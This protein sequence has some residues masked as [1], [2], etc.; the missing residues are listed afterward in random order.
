MFFKWGCIWCLKTG[1]CHSLF[2]RVGKI[3]S[4][5]DQW[6]WNFNLL[7]CSQVWN[8]SSVNNCS[9][10]GHHLL[11]YWK[12]PSWSVH[13][14]YFSFLRECCLF[15]SNP[16]S[17]VMS[18]QLYEKTPNRC[19]HDSSKRLP[20]W[21]ILKLLLLLLSFSY[22]WSVV[23]IVD[24]VLVNVI[25]KKWN[26]MKWSR[27]RLCKNWKISFFLLFL[28]SIWKKKCWEKVWFWKTF[29]GAIP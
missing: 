10:F 7:I 25:F 17:L 8:V 4:L 5:K 14:V 26:E 27:N 22:C 24:V 28:D 11:M 13:S 29:Y 21:F 15:T 2:L 1:M 6:F 23:V 9:Y 16:I 12:M 19:E 20:G 18:L 3:N